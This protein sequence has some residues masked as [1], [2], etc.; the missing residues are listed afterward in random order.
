MNVISNKYLTFAFRVILGAIFVYASL[1]KIAYVDQFAKAIYYYHFLPGW[2][3]NLLAVFM[4]W[5]ELI[6]GICLI[7]GLMPRGAVALINVLLVMFFIALLSA[8]VR[9]INI[10]CGCFSGSGHARS[11][12]INVILRD[13]PMLI[14][15]IQIF[16]FGRDFLSIHKLRP[17]AGQ[18]L[19]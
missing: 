17:E 16:F 5:I 14:M 8:L 15:G 9:G 6:A 4:P 3:I 2:A 12:A 13:I 18:S 1:Y 19:P 11:S 10:D 7:I